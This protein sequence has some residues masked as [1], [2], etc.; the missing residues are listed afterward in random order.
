MTETV[1]V[2][3]D[4]RMFALVKDENGDCFFKVVCGG[5]AMYEA[6]IKLTDEEMDS[7][8]SE[9]KRYLENLAYKISTNSK[10]YENRM[11]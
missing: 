1:I 8:N 5:M 7:Y 10:Q 4:D 11:I 2:K 3:D 9:G 6:K